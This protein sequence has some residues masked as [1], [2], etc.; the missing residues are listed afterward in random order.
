MIP[1]FYLFC[2]GVSKFPWLKQPGPGTKLEDRN[3]SQGAS[4]K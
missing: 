4:S 1:P 3:R 2:Q